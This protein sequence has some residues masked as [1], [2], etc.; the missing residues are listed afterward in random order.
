MSEER[1][2]QR[3][4]I[5]DA[6]LS[7][8]QIG[9]RAPLCPDCKEPLVARQLDRRFMEDDRY[10]ECT[11]GHVWELSEPEERAPAIPGRIKE[12]DILRIDGAPP[13]RVTKVIPAR[14]GDGLVSYVLEAVEDDTSASE[15]GR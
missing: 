11:N 10:Q 7:Q 8:G 9:E 5:T 4:P 13:M 1:V 2:I 6:R 3:G 14:A 12:G 15:S